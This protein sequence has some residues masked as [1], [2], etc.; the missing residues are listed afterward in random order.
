[1]FSAKSRVALSGGEPARG[2][3]LCELSGTLELN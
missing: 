1:M 2:A 3:S